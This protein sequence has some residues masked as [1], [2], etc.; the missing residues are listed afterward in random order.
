MPFVLVL[1]QQEPAVREPHVT[2]WEHFLRWSTE[3]WGLAGG[4]A[5]LLFFAILVVLTV[6]VERVSMFVVGR[7]TSRTDT[8]VDD[9]FVAGIPTIVRA[10]CVMLALTVLS[11]AFLPPQRQEFA[12]RAVKAIAVVTVGILATRLVL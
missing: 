9:V 5:L 8:K 7:L 3:Q 4:W 10:V 11:E 1:A 6:L 12:T 2:L